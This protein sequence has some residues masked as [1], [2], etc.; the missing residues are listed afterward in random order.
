M[1]MSRISALVTIVLALTSGCR[2][3]EHAEIAPPIHPDQERI[4]VLDLGN[5][6]TLTL[7]RVSAGTFTMGSPD[8]EKGF[9]RGEAPQREVTLTKPFYIGIFEVTQE[10]YEAVIGT[11]PSR[12]VQAKHPVVNV[13]KDD[14]A[15][16]CNRLA[17]KTGLQVRL[18]TEAEWEYACRAGS[19]TRFSFGDNEHELGDHAWYAD[20][21]GGNS[22]PVGQKKPNRFGLYDMHGNV[23]E[24]CSDWY[25]ADYYG[26]GHNIDPKGP[27]FTRFRPSVLRGGSYCNSPQRCRST[28]RGTLAHSLRDGNIGF[29]IVAC[30]E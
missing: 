22:H 2:P 6:V 3:G 9:F 26:E 27:E 20:N 12:I 13:S 24:W 10:Q 25:T 19:Q 28:W 11:N 23:F 17:E 30:R 5:S 8:T 29:R 4:L 14:A 7:A 15:A 18:A 21:S 16:F 1:V